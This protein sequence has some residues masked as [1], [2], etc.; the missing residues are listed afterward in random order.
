MLTYLIIWTGIHRTALFGGVAIGLWIA[1]YTY[2]LKYDIRNYFKNRRA[3]RW[4]V[5]MAKKSVTAGRAGL[6]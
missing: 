2:Y 3:H 5:D 1:S 6:R 4:G